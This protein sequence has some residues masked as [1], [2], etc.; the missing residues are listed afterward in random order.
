[1]SNITLISDY[2]VLNFNDKNILFIGGAISVDRNWRYTEKQ[3]FGVYSDY[4]L[5]TE[6]WWHDELFNFDELKLNDSRDIDIVVTHTA[7]EYCSIDNR[8]GFGSF[9]E[10]L[11]MDD[12]KLKDNL[13]EERFLMTKAFDILKRNNNIIT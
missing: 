12:H 9:V 2:T 5:G 6:S 8:I 4:K 7:P 3:R 11:F 10:G 1:M 13:L